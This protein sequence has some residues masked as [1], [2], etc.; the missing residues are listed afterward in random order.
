MQIVTGKTGVPHVTSVQDRALNQGLAGRECYIL[1]TGDNLAPEIHSANEIRINGG[2]LIVQGCL[3][4][5]DY[6]S[7]DTV[8]IANGSQGMKRKDLIVARYTYDAETQ[9]E[10]IEWAV[11]QGE[12][13][14]STPAVPEISNT[15]DIQALDPAVDTAVFAVTLSGVS[16]ESV[17]A[18]VPVLGSLGG[19][20]KLLWSGN[21][22][23]GASANVQLSEAVSAQA[24][25]IVLQFGLTSSGTSTVYG[26]CENL[27]VFKEQVGLLNSSFVVNLG[28]VAFTTNA[29]KRVFISDTNITGDYYNSVDGKQAGVTF[30]N[31]RARLVRVWG[32]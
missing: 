20:L 14:A 10:K 23:M 22:M 15:G 1:D 13:S 25:G 29:R 28:A 16:I 7:Y 19:G 24:H 11:L 26:D 21:E 3:C 12:P 30:T 32:W 2:A 5:V 9:T 17:E 8:T 27:V 18:V 4:T 31:T 6:G